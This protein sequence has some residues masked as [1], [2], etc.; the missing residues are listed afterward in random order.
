MLARFFFVTEEQQEQESRI[1]GVRMKNFG[2]AILPAGR[3][4]LSFL[5]W[6]LLLGKLWIWLWTVEK[7]RRMRTREWRTSMGE[8]GL[9]GRA[10]DHWGNIAIG[11]SWLSF[12]PAERIIS[13]LSQLNVD[14]EGEFSGSR[15][16]RIF[17]W[18]GVPYPQLS[19]LNQEHFIWSFDW[20][21][22]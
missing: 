11:F 2:F 10:V 17:K 5:F 14:N 13:S 20:K 6:L 16:C 9:Y 21:G 1:L 19:G 18:G 3:L 22:L 15:I 4:L 7:I 12:Y 8:A